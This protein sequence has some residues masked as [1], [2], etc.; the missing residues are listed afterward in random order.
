M[1]VLFATGEAF[2]F[3][4]TGGLGDVSYSLPKALVQKE[5]V[6]I[7]VI[8]P[9][10]S[11]ISSELLKN[12]KHLGHKEI[13]VAHHNEYVG[14]E[15]VELEGVIYYFVDN[16]RYFRRLNVYGEYDD[17]ERFLFFSK[18]VVETMDIT[19]FKPD[20]IHCNDWQTGLIPIYLKERG[21]Y[22]VKTVFSIH[23]LRFQGFFYNN[24]IED[25]LEI[26]RARYFQDDGI[27][28]YDMISFL[29]AGVV[30]SD[31]ITTVSD[32][33]AEE[34]KTPEFGE[35]IHGLFQKYDYKLSGIVNG[36]DKASYPLSKKSHKTLKANLQAKLGLEIEEATPLVAIITRLDRQKGID[37]IIDKFD[38]MMSL[39]IQ[40]V[41]LGTGEKNYENFFRYKES[42]YR[43][44]VCSY[45]GFDQAL[46][47]EIYAGADIFLMPSVFEPC[48]L[49]QMIAMR[50]GCI[51]VVR[52]TGGLKDTVKPYNEYTGEGD[53]FGFKQANSEDMVKALRYAVTMY[54]RPEVWKE[55]IANAKK[56]DNSWKEPAKRYKE[57]YQKLL[58]N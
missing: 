24:V 5:K 57:I 37:F 55:I 4:K 21:I 26:D 15:E 30:Y 28:Y 20:I 6:D 27:R 23:N 46:S 52:E 49:S 51:P 40:F 41:L 36:I 11:K 43:G 48:G 13:W 38:E 3:V 7:R 14:I 1:K 16:E 18:A 54:H 32:S 50:Y 58:E 53:G 44:Y 25:L 10:Y 8:L 56:R 12:A 2:P 9:K 17:C 31:Y 29:K 33:Y 22:D 34:I 45:I 42:Q 39:G 47:T 19:G 35:G